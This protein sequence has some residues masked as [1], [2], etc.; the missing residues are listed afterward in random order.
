MKAPPSKKQLNQADIRN[1]FIPTGRVLPS[2]RPRLVPE[3]NEQ[4]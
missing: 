4:D 1:I 3:V 2:K